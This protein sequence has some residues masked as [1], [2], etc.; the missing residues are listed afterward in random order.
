[1]LLN[2]ASAAFTL[3]KDGGQT[4]LPAILQF[5]GITSLEQKILL[6]ALALKSDA[7]ATES[8]IQLLNI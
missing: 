1:M 6:K 5:L 8:G 7:I 4:I 2:G 3:K